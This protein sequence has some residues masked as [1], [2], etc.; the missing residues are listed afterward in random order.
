MWSASSWICLWSYNMNLQSLETLKQ[1]NC[2]C[3][4][5]L[6]QLS[7]DALNCCPALSVSLQLSPRTHKQL[8]IHRSTFTMVSVLHFSCAESDNS[9]A[10]ELPCWVSATCHCHQTETSWTPAER[11]HYECLM[12]WPLLYIYRCCGW[13]C[14]WPLR[15]AVAKQL[16]YYF[17]HMH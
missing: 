2:Y 11:E 17:M 5:L 3:H 8:A 1:V 6:L 7:E 16:V 4:T 15:P 14:T 9:P 13:A 12:A 10:G